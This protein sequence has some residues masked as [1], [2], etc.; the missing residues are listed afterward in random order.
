[1]KLE[2]I[3]Q[4]HIAGLAIVGAVLL[5]MGQDNTMLP[6][7]AVFAAVT[8]VIFTDTLHW[9]HLNRSVANGLALLALFFS[10]TDFMQANT[11]SQLLAIAHLLIYLQIVLFYQR[12]NDRL[13]WQ[14]AVLSLLQIVVAAALNVGVEF[15][16]GLIMYAAVAFST[17]AFFYA[18]REVN[19]CTQSS[20]NRNAT[21]RRHRRRA[22]RPAAVWDRLLQRKP[23]LRP[24]QTRE[25]LGRQV[26][27]WGLLRQTV[28]IG[29]TTL[30]FAFLLF[31]AAPRLDGTGRR[32]V[33]QNT[34]AVVGFSREI[35]LDEMGQIL[36]S[37]EPVMRVIFREPETKE[38]YRFYGDPYFRGAV[39]GT[40]SQREDGV[41]RWSRLDLPDYAVDRLGGGLQRLNAPPS[42]L[43][44]VRQD[45]LLQPLDHPVMFGIPP[46]YALPWTPV[47]V[48]VN[49]LTRKLSADAQYSGHPPGEFRYV[50]GTTGILGGLQ[51]DVTPYPQRSLSQEN[52]VVLAAEKRELLRFSERRFPTLKRIADEIGREQRANRASRATLARM[53]RNHF[54]APNRYTY[55][56]DFR[57]V[58]R[59]PQVDPIEDFVANHRTGHCEYFAS[60][61]VMML[62]SQGLP[63][64]LVTGFRGGEY[65]ALGGYYQVLQGHAHA[66]VEVYLEAD[67]VAREVPPGSDLSPLGGW[68]RLDPTPGSDLDR[69]RQYQRGPMDVVDDVLD[70]ARTLWSDYIMGLTARR[71]RESIYDPVSERTNQVSWSAVAQR[72][73]SARDAVVSRV[74][75]VFTTRSGWALMLSV[76]AAF[77]GYYVLRS[78]WRH[79]RKSRA[80]RVVRRWHARA[81]GRPERA[82]LVSQAVSIRFY[83]KLEEVL[84]QLGMSRAAHVTP[85]EFAAQATTRLK[86]AEFSVE[87]QQVPGRTVNALYRVRFG[88][89]V[90]EDADAGAIEDGLQDL[91]R[92][93]SAHKTQASVPRSNSRGS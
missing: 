19:R 16:V 66:W 37:S 62:R 26:A 41:A 4:I 83:S 21:R 53:L 80:M 72:L 48:Q 18:F 78:Q 38:L 40:Y 12:K 22:M 67:E 31:F 32:G 56:L 52:R 79:V 74:R 42:G 61:L 8:S 88:C 14:L 7:L 69:A 57:S 30:V 87:V 11:R 70:Y 82:E 49:P 50:L 86:A 76:A 28:A 27:G 75:Q 46:A 55:T 77:G 5:G 36:D 92:A 64:R 10:L 63:A 34:T 71:Q 20:E 54:L 23:V 39:W 91:E 58:K 44:V 17:L 59:R 90:L 6:L 47:D 2:R 25:E 13:Y 9:F 60:A 68:L 29:S 65:N 89:L 3:V 45:I 24:L 85:R 84:G 51:V 43:A 73:T 93:V 1:M 15:G 35:T 81:A 33:I